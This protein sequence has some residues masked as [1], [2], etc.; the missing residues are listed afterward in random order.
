MARPVAALRPPT[1]RQLEILRA[2]A[3]MAAA[4]GISPTIK[5]MGRKMGC[6]SPSA[7]CSGMRS[8]VA[9]GYL[10]HEPQVARAYTLT[11][12]ARSILG[13]QSGDASA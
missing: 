10:A 5:E 13:G 11:E 1:N 6:A 12:K 9:K 8:L 3:A 2:F 4:R 7:L